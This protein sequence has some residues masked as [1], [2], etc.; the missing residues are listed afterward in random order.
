MIQAITLKKRQISS[1]QIFM[2]TMFVVNAGNYAYNLILGRF[3]GPKAFADAAILITF[4]LVL[5]FVGMT[6]QIV[7]KYSV[8]L[9]G[10]LKSKFIKT[11]SKVSIAIGVFI[12]FL[13]VFFS[14]NLQTLLH[15]ETD[16][17]FYLFGIGIPLYFLMSV[18][19]GIYQGENNSFGESWSRKSSIDKIEALERVGIKQGDAFKLSGV[20]FEDFGEDLQGALKGDVEDARNRMKAQKA[21]LNSLF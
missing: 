14:K 18:N 3:L 11:I 12:G 4:L 17:M 9:E 13:F 6:F 15:T 5:S 7:T 16:T 21:F 2:L 20:E 1:E 19:R 10:E 8:L